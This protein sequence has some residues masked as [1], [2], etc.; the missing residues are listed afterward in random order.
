MRSALSEEFTT[1]RADINAV[2]AEIASNAGAIRAEMSSIET[3]NEDMKGGLSTWSDEVNTLQT[4]VAELQSELVKLRDKSEDMEVRMKCGNIRIVGVEER[5]NSAS[6][7]E[8]SKI[9]KHGDAER[10]RVIIAKLRH[11][12][13]SQSSSPADL[14]W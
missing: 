4:T 9:I 11:S 14:Q 12:E 8:V 7:K 1:L 3:D 2:R 10:P 13:E 5:P 6:P